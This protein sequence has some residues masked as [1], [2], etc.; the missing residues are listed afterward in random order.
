[1]VASPIEGTKH[2]APWFVGERDN[3]NTRVGGTAALDAL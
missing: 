1:M 3:A 2:Y